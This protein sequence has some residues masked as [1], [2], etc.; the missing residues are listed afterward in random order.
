MKKQIAR[1]EKK[2]KEIK[3]TNHLRENKKQLSKDTKYRK[4][5]PYPPKPSHGTQNFCHF[6]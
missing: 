1:R 6:F 5:K 4:I 2:N 3:I